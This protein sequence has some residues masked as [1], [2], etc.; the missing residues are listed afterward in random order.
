MEFGRQIN[1]TNKHLHGVRLEGFGQQR[2]PSVGERRVG[3]SRR[4]VL[5]LGD[6]ILGIPLRFQHCLGEDCPRKHR[7]LE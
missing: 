6:H 5:H 1:E 3:R 7:K 4:S 2:R